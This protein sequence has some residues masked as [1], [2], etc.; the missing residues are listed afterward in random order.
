[1]QY[2]LKQKGGITG[3]AYEESK[4]INGVEISF[5]PAGHVAG[6]A[7]V[8]V[9]YHGEV[10]VV[11]GDYK[12]HPDPVAADFEPIQCHHFVTESTFGLP[13]Y[14]W[15]DPEVTYKEMAEWITRNQEEG[16]TSLI[17]AYSLGKAQRI[18]KALQPYGFKVFTHGAV[19]PMNEL[20]R[21]HGWMD[22]P[23]TYLDRQRSVK[24]LDGAVVIAP[25]SA[26]GSGWTNR[27][28]KLRTSTASGW[29]QLRGMRRRRSV[30]K[31]F[32]LSDHADWTGLIKAVEWSGAENIYVG[33][34]YTESFSKWLREAKH[35]NAQAIP[36][37]IGRNENEDD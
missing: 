6:S 3:L 35:L 17:T 8:R 7:Q 36:A 37:L 5:H 21:R 33:H 23:S 18:L 14:K 20:M 31:G 24:D 26:L 32:V 19:E 10:W 16:H 1:L 22:A 12:I 15:K 25:P 4:S 29:M 13:V 9:E 2:R 30:D 11:T 34:G 27:F 28:K